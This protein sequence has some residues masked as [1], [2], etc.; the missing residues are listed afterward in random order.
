M[1]WTRENSKFSNVGEFYF[2]FRLFSPLFRFNVVSGV[3]DGS[4]CCAKC[5][6]RNL[7]AINYKSKVQKCQCLEAN[8]QDKIETNQEPGFF[9]EKC[10]V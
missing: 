5:A 9:W 3:E 10:L 7:K 1:V 4:E 6:A 8:G 2:E